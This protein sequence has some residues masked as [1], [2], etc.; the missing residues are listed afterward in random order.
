MTI[1]DYYGKL[2]KLWD[3]LGNFEQLSACKCGKCTC[4]LGSELEKR[5]E[6]EKVHLFLMGLDE[7]RFG[8]T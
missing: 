3:E 6:E 2:K 5:R 4:N 1:M 8:T 7:Q